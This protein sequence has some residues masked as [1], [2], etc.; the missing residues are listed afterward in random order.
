M[1]LSLIK[2]ILINYN[3][4]KNSTDTE[5]KFEDKSK[6]FMF[7]EKEDVELLL[8]NYKNFIMNYIKRTEELVLNINDPHKYQF[9]SYYGMYPSGFH[10][11]Y[12]LMINENEKYCPP[13]L[14]DKSDFLRIIIYTGA[15]ETLKFSLKIGPAD[16]EFT[17]YKRRITASSPT[18]AEKIRVKGDSISITFRKHEG[19][20]Y[21]ALNDNLVSSINNN[22][23][24]ISPKYCIY[25]KKGNI[26]LVSSQYI[27]NSFYQSLEFRGT[28]NFDNRI[29]EINSDS[30]SYR[31]KWERQSNALYSL[32]LSLNVISDIRY[33]V[34]LYS[35]NMSSE[36]LF[37]IDKV[38]ASGRRLAAHFY[39]SFV[40]W[41][42]WRP[43]QGA[44]PETGFWDWN[45]WANGL[46][47]GT[48]ALC[49]RLID[50]DLDPNSISVFQ[51]K[52]TSWLTSTRRVNFIPGHH[53]PHWKHWLGR[54]TNHGIVIYA[55]YLLATKIL[56]IS[57]I[58]ENIEIENDLIHVLDN[59]FPD[60]SY[61]E[62][63]GYIIFAVGHIIPYVWSGFKS[64]RLD[65]SSY[66]QSKFSKLSKINQ[67][68]NAVSGSNGQPFGNFGDYQ[69]TNWLG[70][71]VPYFSR[72]I[73]HACGVYTIRQC[74]A[75][76]NEI[77]TD[78]Y[79]ALAILLPILKTRIDYVDENVK[80]TKYE[81]IRSASIEYFYKS[82]KIGSLFVFGS[83]LHKT[84]NRSHCCG[85]IIFEFNEKEIL[86][87]RPG[88][89][90]HNH[91]VICPIKYGKLSE[92]GYDRSYSGDVDT[93]FVNKNIHIINF[94]V[95]FDKKI[96]DDFQMLTFR[97]SVISYFNEYPILIVI[98]RMMMT[99]PRDMALLFNV[100]NHILSGDSKAIIE[101]DFLIRNFIHYNEKFT[102]GT[103]STIDNK[104]MYI[105]L[106][107]IHQ[108]KRHQY[109]KSYSYTMVT[110]M[111]NNRIFDKIIEFDEN[112]SCLSLRLGENR[113]RIYESFDK[114]R[115]DYDGEMLPID[116]DWCDSA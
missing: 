57:E 8:N 51:Q 112:L 82:K 92:V 40:Q 4:I 61:L 102:D 95:N 97:R 106:D 20:H 107:S 114:L 39:S 108:S 81:H 30:L 14:S 27:Y 32:F 34:L 79:A 75:G 6:K 91:N 31:Y 36:E 104:L 7:Y 87:E 53:F 71:S 15:A 73:S 58:E 84:H 80:M 98:S 13:F 48:Y 44:Y 37:A 52:A 100:N 28:N 74:I 60:G 2:K 29:Y 101:N 41:P 110:V 56:G 109:N 10:N 22:Y 90:F 17:K 45:N 78:S 3:G 89:S 16:I 63:P 103:I 46:L 115:V 99:E 94:K 26:I 85:N 116:L 68:L 49:A 86:I 77:G 18:F 23:V 43:A 25:V 19:T 50:K 33:Y 47:P 5:Y 105:N 62:G 1:I 69:L 67:Y 66:C 113:L 42:A 21:I 96:V 12:G 93:K 9:Y 72:A 111:Y 55:S 11:L 54:S 83:R 24:S 59:S 64:S 35:I 70:S 88:I 65:W 76:G 38:L